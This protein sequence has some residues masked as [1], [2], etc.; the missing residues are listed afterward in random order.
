MSKIPKNKLV[1]THIYTLSD[2]DN[3]IRYVGKTVR[4]LEDRLK[5]HIHVAKSGKIKNHRTNWINSLLKLSII[6]IITEIDSCPWNK[7]SNLE[8]Y[9]I[10]Y[11][12]ELGFDLVNETLGGEGNLGYTK[13]K[14][15]IKKLKFSLQNRLGPVYQYD[16]NGNFIKMWNNPSEAAHSLGKEKAEGITRCLKGKRQ[17]YKGFR[18]TNYYEIDPEIVIQKTN[19]RKTKKS[20]LNKRARRVIQYDLNGNE[21]NRFDSPWKAC[22]A[23]GKNVNSSSNITQVCLGKKQTVFGYK[24]KYE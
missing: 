1:L 14:E 7:S 8:Q 17:I 6:P 16:I 2:N 12:K 18:W 3:N 13:S 15:T 4:K 21:L 9:Y 24:W 20:F 22:Q 19:F 23:L 5:E 10:K 11:Y